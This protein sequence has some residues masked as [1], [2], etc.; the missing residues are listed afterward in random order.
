M[1]ERLAKTAETTKT[2]TGSGGS[3]RHLLLGRRAEDLAADYVRRL[4]WTVLSRNFSC[5]LGELDIVA[6]DKEGKELVV[7]EV[8]YR[9]FGDMQSPADS[10]GP[11]KLRSL[12]SAGRVWVEEQNW[13]GPWRI[14]LVGV[15]A[16]PHAPE[17]RWKL[18]HIPD[19]TGGNFP[20]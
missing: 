9:T 18:E 2:E 13:T 20:F 17:A 10:V 8:R 4:G 3:S 6:L 7:V 15:T 16:S 1:T 11:K 12:V 5:R 19:I 14:D